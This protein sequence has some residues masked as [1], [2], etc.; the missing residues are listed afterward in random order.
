MKRYVLFAAT[1]LLLY[2]ITPAYAGPSREIIELQQQVQQLLTLQQH[3]DQ[4]M[5]VLQDRVD[6]LVQRTD[7]SLARVS[8]NVDRLEKVTQQQSA[9]SETCVDQVTGQTQPLHDAL[10]E[11]KG[12]MAAMNRQL[13]EMQ[14]GK[15][16][17]VNASAP[18]TQSPQ[19]VQGAANQSAAPAQ[20][21]PTPPQ[22]Q[23]GVA[24][25]PK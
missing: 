18:Q 16:G 11:L 12:S 1:I 24:V 10:A 23:Q 21:V 6:K 5:G 3:I 15:S 8:A 2:M 4:Q 13:A 22:N 7:E 17:V 14:G 9:A 19:S 25:N 20:G